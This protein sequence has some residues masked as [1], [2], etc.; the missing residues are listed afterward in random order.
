M[1]H[2]LADD[3]VVE[4]GDRLHAASSPQRDRLRTLIDPAAGDF[5]VLSLQRA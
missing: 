2:L 3:D 1:P 4:F 5:D